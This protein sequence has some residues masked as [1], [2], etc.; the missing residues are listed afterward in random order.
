LVKIA[1]LDERK[2]D[3]NSPSSEYGCRWKYLGL[4]TLD[5]RMTDGKFK[6]TKQK[7]V[8]KCSNWAEKHMSMADKEALIKSVA[9]AIPT[10]TMGVFKLPAITCE[11][12]TKLIHK[13][14]WGEENGQRKVHWVAYLQMY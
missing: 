3:A 4:P 13:F 11:D 10:Y 6:Y 7:L 2:G 14:W 5:G 9:Q 12:F 8:N 1:R